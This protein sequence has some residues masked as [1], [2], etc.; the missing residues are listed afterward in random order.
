MKAL[1]LIGALVSPSMARSGG[2]CA[3]SGPDGHARR[4]PRSRRYL[5]FGV[6]FVL[7]GIVAQAMTAAT[8]ALYARGD[9]DLL[10]SSP[11]SARAVL[12]AR[13]LAIAA[14]AIAWFAIV[15]LP[16]ANVNALAGHLHWLAIYPAL[17]ACGLFG[18]GIGVV[19]ALALFR[20][21]RAKTR[22]PRLADRRDHRR[23]LLHARRCKAMRRRRATR[24][25]R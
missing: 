20:G 17:L 10:F 1:A 12:G 7:P 6:L 18:A 23:R 3:I 19:L 11:V 14:N 15:L 8:R 22:A 25:R 13:A 24:A 21:G 9:L 2:G 5:G 16:L 4:T